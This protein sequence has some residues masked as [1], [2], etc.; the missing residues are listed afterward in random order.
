MIGRTTDPF[1]REKGIHPSHRERKFRPG[2][3][4]RVGFALPVLHQALPPVPSQFITLV[5][6]PG[7]WPVRMIDSALENQGIDAVRRELPGQQSG[8]Q[9][10]SHNHDG[11]LGK[12]GRHDQGWLR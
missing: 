3:A 10:T 1:A 7:F 8:T 6:K 11:A 12:F 4:Q 2:M 5:G 9:T